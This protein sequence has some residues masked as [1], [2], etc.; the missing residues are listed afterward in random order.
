[1]QLT[2]QVLQNRAFREIK[3]FLEQLYSSLAAVNTPRVGERKNMHLLLAFF[4]VTAFVN[5]NTVKSAE[6]G[7]HMISTL[8]VYVED[9]LNSFEEGNPAIDVPDIAMI[10]ARVDYLHSGS[11]E[12]AKVFRLATAKAPFQ[13]QKPKR[14]N[15]T[16]RVVVTKKVSDEQQALNDY[17]QAV[18]YLQQG[19]VAEAQDKLRSALVINPMFD[20]AR[21]TLV[22]LLVENNRVN[23]AIYTLKTGI[24]ISPAN[25]GFAQILARLQLDSG[26]LQESLQTLE[27]S[28]AYANN[29]SPFHVLMA[30]VLQR[31]GY[32]QKAILHYEHALNNG[33]TTSAWLVGLGV[34]LEANGQLDKARQAF[35]K[36]GRGKLSPTLALFVSQKLKALP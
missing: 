5:I 35:K 32:H 30:S 29:H 28:V 12:D 21:Q 2:K 10:S 25:I 18:G 1:M 17:Q 24:E 9:G 11:H 3:V 4:A 16:D 13:V 8:S 14:N 7:A 23:E 20:D 31:L 36:A 27:A 33:A 34:S 19:R 6:S 15:A 22:G 26:F